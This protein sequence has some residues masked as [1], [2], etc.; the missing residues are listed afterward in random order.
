MPKDKKELAL[1][2]LSPFE[3]HEREA[4]RRMIARARD[5]A[6]VA[7]T[8]SVEAPISRFNGLQT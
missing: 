3:R 6:L 2:V 1:Y 8:E 5:A 4:V 7:A